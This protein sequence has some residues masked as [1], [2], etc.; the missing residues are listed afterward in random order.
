MYSTTGQ[1]NVA[2]G[3]RFW[4][5]IDERKTFKK[6][7]YVTLE[8]KFFIFIIII[9]YLHFFNIIKYY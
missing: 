2:C 4:L 5:P 6:S 7:Q 8:V 1:V 9:I 3:P